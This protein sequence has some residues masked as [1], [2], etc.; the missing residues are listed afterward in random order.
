MLVWMLVYQWDVQN[1]SQI[2]IPRSWSKL[3]HDRAFSLDLGLKG[4][5]SKSTNGTSK[6]LL[7]FQFP[8]SWS[9][10]KL[11]RAFSLDLGLKGEKIARNVTKVG[12]DACLQMGHPNLFSIFNSEKLVKDETR[13]CVFSRVG[14]RWEENSSEC[15]E[16]WCAHLPTNG[17]SKS[18]LKF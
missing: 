9:N 4:V 7:N 13:P 17:T 11:D 16:S 10:S 15:H 18:I 5:K 8:R 3:K 6:S 2:L 14:L 1:Y 12:V